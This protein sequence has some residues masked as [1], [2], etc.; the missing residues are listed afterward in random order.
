MRF[1]GGLSSLALGRQWRIPELRVLALGVVVAV[2]AVT[3]VGFFTDRVQRALSQQASELLG[4]DLVVASPNRPR[5]DLRRTASVA[6]LDLAQ[7]VSFPSV[8]L[9]GAS[10]LLTDVKAVSNGYPL[11]GRVRVATRPFDEPFEV[12]GI[13]APGE[14]WVDLRV[15]QQLG[16]QLGDAVQL[17]E[18]SFT[19][20]RLLTYEPDRGG[21]LF[22]LAPRVLLNEADLPS[23]GLITPAS[24][25]R[26]RLL[27]AGSDAAVARFRTAL[28]GALEPGER[29]QGIRDARPELRAALDRSQQFLGLAAVTAVLLAG[30]A[31]SV[32]APVIG[33]GRS[34]A[35]VSRGS[36]SVASP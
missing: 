9:R 23:T 35:M 10:T 2:A 12:E 22:Q 19:A 14:I 24:R 26:Y 18:R 17:G 31:I 7:T 11:R 21:D 1:R 25:V 36:G 29:L 4:A 33:S 34:T 20:S 3:S 30:A 6:G 13:P 27:L 16:M 15:L 28:D 32:A 5:A 8:I